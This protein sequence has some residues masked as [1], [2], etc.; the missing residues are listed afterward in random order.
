MAASSMR[1]G[2]LHLIREHCPRPDR[3]L[4]SQARPNVTT[5]VVSETLSKVDGIKNWEALTSIQAK[6]SYPQKD[7]S[8]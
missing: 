6:Q 5:Q 8:G 3:G 4:G 7:V 1:A 2:I